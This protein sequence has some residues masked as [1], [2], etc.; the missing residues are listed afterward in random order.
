MPSLSNSDSTPT[1]VAADSSSDIADGAVS[2][3]SA[4]S[5]SSSVSTSRLSEMW[6]YLW[7]PFLISLS[8]EI[9][10]SKADS[11]I[12]LPS[13]LDHDSPPSTCPLPDQKLY[14]R[15]II[16]I[17]SHP[18][19]GAS[20]RLSNATGASYI[21]ASYVKFIESAGA[22]V[23]P[24]IYN[25]PLEVLYQKL[26]LVNGVL[27]TGGWAKR[28]LYFEVAQ[29]IFQRVLEKN[30][31]GDHFP[32]YAICLGFE[33]LSMAISKDRN[34]LESF[35]ASDAATTLEFTSNVNIEGTVFQRFPPDLLKKLGTDCLVMQNH[36]YGISPE[37]FRENSEL[38][39][40][41]N[42]LTTCT[43]E[44]DKV[45][46]S[47]VQGRY[48]PVTGFQWHPEKNAFEWGLTRIPHSE[49]AIQVT[50]HAAN[51]LVSEARKS[52]NRPSPQKVLDNLIYNY[53]PTYCGKA[54]RGYDEVYI[55]T[56][57]SM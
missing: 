31:A 20:G 54:G 49:D 23:I 43:D 14:H 32:L 30:D 48:Y 10:P 38:S 55:F 45:Y 52:L 21:A 15:P 25:E 39:S 22:R 5:S 35:S 33:I 36:R 44:D 9:V 50:Q 4:P 3:S 18:G 19:D 51:F 6:S 28:G 16:G 37:R 7:I 40:F 17:L 53:S 1:A 56:R 12:L 2:Y 34:I 27:F 47:T 26:E 13:Q 46:V 42:I 41:F 57:S 29:K 11:A 24:L 8:R